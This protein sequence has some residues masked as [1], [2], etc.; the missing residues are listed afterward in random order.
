M[1]TLEE[2]AELAGR[3]LFLA[4][5]STVRADGSVQS[6]VVNAGV[7]RNPLGGEEAG[8]VVGFVTY[9]KT[10]LANLRARPQVTLTFRFGWAWATVEGR[11]ELIGP[12][13]P[14]AGVDAE[15]LALLLREVFTAAGGSHDDWDAY[16]REMA[17]QR[18][19][20]VLV[21]PGRI[22]SN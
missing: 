5:V 17:E 14:V 4:V 12:D 21:T 13:D 20:V 8:Q 18:R 6:S 10:K 7:L 3:E 2:V 15:R 19:T 11:A 22:Y 16:D 1:T 9:G